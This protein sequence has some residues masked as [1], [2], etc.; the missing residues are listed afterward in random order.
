MRGDAT[1]GID[2][3]YLAESLARIQRD[4]FVECLLCGSAR[5]Q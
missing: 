3:S 4:E 5:R 1:S 2:D